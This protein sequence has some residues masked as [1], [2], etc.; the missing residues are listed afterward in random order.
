[1]TPQTP[2]PGTPEIQHG[3]CDRCGSTWTGDE[4]DT[5]VSACGQ[6]TACDACYE[7]AP[8]VVRDYLSGRLS[9]TGREPT[10]AYMGQAVAS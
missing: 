2:E 5:G 8:E 9:R 4:S 6:W 3:P 7:S 1:M 10:D